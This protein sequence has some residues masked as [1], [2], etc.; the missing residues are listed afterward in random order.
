MDLKAA[1]HAPFDLRLAGLACAVS[2]RTV[3]WNTM[4]DT[5]VASYSLFSLSCVYI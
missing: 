5:D 1:T 4:A 2:K 3:E